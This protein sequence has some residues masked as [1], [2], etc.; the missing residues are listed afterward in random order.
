[1]SAPIWSTVFIFAIAAF[2][3]WYTGERPP[4]LDAKTLLEGVLF[5]YAHLIGKPV[6]MLDNLKWAQRIYGIANQ[7]VY[8]NDSGNLVVTPKDSSHGTADND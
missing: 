3:G 8:R 7:R 4:N 5:G 2:F 6:L 1:V